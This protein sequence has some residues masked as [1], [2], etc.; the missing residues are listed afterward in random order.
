MA[1]K[2]FG[3]SLDEKVLQEL[4]QLVDKHQFPNRSQA[5]RYLI[6]EHLV[7]ENWRENRLVAGTVTLLYD[8]HKRDLSVQSN[9]IQHAHHDLVLSMQHIH[10][11][12]NNCLETI[13]L[14]GRAGRLLDLSDKL[15]GLKGV[16][17]GKLVMTSL[18]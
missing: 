17:H 13:T 3:V 12:H 5:I 18:D 4:D 15:I 14:K 7:E 2:R 1:I 9:N 6:K 11:D 8:H 10:L 16:K